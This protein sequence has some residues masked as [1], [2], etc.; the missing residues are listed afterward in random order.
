ML[1]FEFFQGERE[2]ESRESE[3]GD[4]ER[5]RERSKGG[6]GERGNVQ[7]RMMVLGKKGVSICSLCK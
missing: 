6:D 1:D 3:E 5:E 7:N 4:V 2:R